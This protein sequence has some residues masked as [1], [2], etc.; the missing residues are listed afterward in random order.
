MRWL[1]CILVVAAGCVAGGPGGGKGSS[2]NPSDPGPEIDGAY[3]RPALG[4]CVGG[5]GGAIRCSGS[6]CVVLD[7]AS[8][9]ASTTCF[10]AYT[11][12]G[13]GGLTFRACFPIDT[14]ST[15]AGSCAS[16][17]ADA[18]VTR[19]DCAGV[20]RGTSIFSSFVRCQ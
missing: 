17:T 11:D 19:E 3:L 6:P 18:C 2:S 5:V 10:V 4:A 13:A 20:Y 8:C 9:A 16:L 1:A 7:E 15:A 12:D 14:R